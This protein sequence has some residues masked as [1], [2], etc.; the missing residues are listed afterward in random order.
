MKFNLP[1]VQS[2]SVNLYIIEILK[3]NTDAVRERAAYLIRA[4]SFQLEAQRQLTERRDGNRAGGLGDLAAA[5]GY[6]D[7]LV[8]EAHRN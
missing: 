2:E 3:C 7:L 8:P 4:D 6:G 1:W 5:A